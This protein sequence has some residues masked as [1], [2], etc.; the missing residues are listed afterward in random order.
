MVRGGTVT[1]LQVSGLSSE[2]SCNLKPIDGAGQEMRTLLVAVNRMVSDGT[3]AV[4]MVLRIPQKPPSTENSPPLIM[5]ASGWPIAAF[6]EYSVPALGP[7]PLPI[8]NQSME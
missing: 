6:T 8:A 7:P 3:P 1:S 5:A 2:F 4:E